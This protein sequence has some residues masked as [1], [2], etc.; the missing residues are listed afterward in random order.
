MEIT[1]ATVDGHHLLL[2]ILKQTVF[3]VNL[4][5]LIEQLQEL[6]INKEEAS[7]LYHIAQQ[8]HVL[9]SK[10]LSKPKQYQSLLMLQT[11]ANIH[12]VSSIT[13][14]HQLIMPSFWL[15]LSVETGKLK[16]L[17]EQDGENMDILD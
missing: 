8:V 16:T 14:Q 3:Q 10:T 12:Q 2:I 1:V 9:D 15:V 13:V 5:I 6:A 7:K 4:N 17:G 11:G